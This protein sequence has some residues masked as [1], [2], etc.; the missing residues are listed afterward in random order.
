M[1]GPREAG[2][3]WE[4]VAEAY[5]WR[6]GLKTVRRNFHCRLGEIDLIMED[7][8]CLV[9]TEVRF[10]RGSSHGNGAESVTRSKQ[11]RIIR[12]ARKYLQLR[13]HPIDQPCR[14]DVVSL[15]HDQGKLKVDWIRNAFTGDAPGQR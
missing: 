6:H 11:A 14:F 9:F 13:P 3:H 2:S 10:R 7:G 5:L 1:T 4:R 12:T 15:G 8:E